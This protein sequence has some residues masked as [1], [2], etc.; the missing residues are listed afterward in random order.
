L[1]DPICHQVLID[2]IGEFVTNAVKHGKATEGRIDV[3]NLQSD[4]IQ[5]V[6]QNNGIPVDED[7]KP[8]LG[9][10]MVLQNCL[11][12]EFDNLPDQGVIFTATIPVN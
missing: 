7:F 12:S 10:E 4:V 3:T 1:A 11:T 8:G 9:T 5:L 2:L 6:M